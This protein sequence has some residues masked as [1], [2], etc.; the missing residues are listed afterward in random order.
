VDFGGDPLDQAPL[1]LSARYDLAAARTANDL[2]I[3]R[4]AQEAVYA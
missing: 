3:L 2:T 1:D 4:E